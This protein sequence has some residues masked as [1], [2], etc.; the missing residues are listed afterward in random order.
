[1]DKRDLIIYICFFGL[2]LVFLILVIG[3]SMKLNDFN[4]GLLLLNFWLIIKLIIL[5]IEK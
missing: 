1:M 2:F 5:E 4:I 3:I